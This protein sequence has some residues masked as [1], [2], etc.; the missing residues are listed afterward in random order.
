MKRQVGRW[1]TL[2]KD[3]VTVDSVSGTLSEARW[4]TAPGKDA[5]A[6]NRHVDADGIVESVGD[7]QQ[8]VAWRSFDGVDQFQSLLY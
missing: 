1:K 8:K 4:L 3:L 2:L 5:I 7:S 6:E